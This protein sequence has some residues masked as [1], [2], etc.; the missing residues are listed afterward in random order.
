MNSAY[1]GGLEVEQ[2]K[3]SQVQLIRRQLPYVTFH[4]GEE[5]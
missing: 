2:Q 5:D 3:K 4:Q 1:D